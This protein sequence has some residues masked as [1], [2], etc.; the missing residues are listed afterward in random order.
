MATPCINDTCSITSAIDAVTRKMS[1]NAQLDP[2]GG[3]ICTDG[4]GL[5]VEIYGA[6]AVAAPVDTCFQQLGVS[7]A[8]ELWSIPKQARIHQFSCSDSVGIPQNANQGNFS[9]NPIDQGNAVVNPYACAAFAIITGRFRVRYI[10]ANPSDGLIPPI[11]ECLADSTPDYW[12]PFNADIQCR[13]SID[14]GSSQVISA[15]PDTSGIMRRSDV[16]AGGDGEQKDNWAYFALQLL[17]GA[18]QAVSLSADARHV[19]T[20]GQR[21]MNTAQGANQ[22]GF[23]AEGQIV[24]LPF[25]GASV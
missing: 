16:Q 10:I 1:L 6:P 25:N 8:G 17:V 7:P 23:I 18:S 4:R 24:F 13:L 12:V 2:T 14:G 19:G 9:T 5:G 11:D 20:S 21:N 3:L 22:R 15:Y